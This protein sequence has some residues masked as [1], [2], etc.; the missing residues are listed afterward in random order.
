M[1]RVTR[2]TVVAKSPVVRVRDSSLRVALHDDEDDVEADITSGFRRR[3]LVRHATPNYNALAWDHVDDLPPSLQVYYRACDMYRV[4]PIP[5]VAAVLASYPR[6]VVLKLPKKCGDAALLPVCEVLK[7]DNTILA[8]HARRCRI[9]TS[10]CYLLENVLAVNTTLEEVNLGGNLIG[11][12]G[13]LA[14]ARGLSKNKTLKKLS[15]R[16]NWLYEDG[17][18]ALYDAVRD[19][20][21][22]TFLDISNCGLTVVGVQPFRSLRSRMEVKILGN[23]PVEEFLNSS[24]HFIGFI[25]T[26]FASIYMLY[27][28]DLFPLTH[29]FARVIYCASLLLLFGISTLFHSFMMLE[30]TYYFFQ[31]LDRAAIFLLIAGSYTPMCLIMIEDFLVGKIMLFAAWVL[32]VVGIIK[33]FGVGGAKS[34]GNVFLYVLM[35]WLS[36][37]G[38]REF[39]SCL[40]FEGVSLLLGGGLIYTSGVY[41]YATEEEKPI[42]HAI[43]H[44]FVIAAAACHFIC[45]VKYALPCGDPLPWVDVL[46]MYFSTLLRGSWPHKEL[47]GAIL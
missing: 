15:I 11:P 12:R 31:K 44:L 21:T 37:L 9:T 41:F 13:C 38:T 8:L 40:P 22:L 18:H 28:Q 17:G 36:V 10:G 2:S 25:L 6:V 45:I 3:E 1:P 43:W 14:L 30:K 19:H 20:P 4:E 35:G 47:L 34:Q 33:I 16:S 29:F 27:H 7:V 42:N 39:L 32:A 5:Q 46:K 23:Y 26:V 24:T